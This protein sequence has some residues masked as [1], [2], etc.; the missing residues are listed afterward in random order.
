MPLIERE[1]FD[2]IRSA[3]AGR[4]L[5]LSEIGNRAVDA[6]IATRFPSYAVRHDNKVVWLIHQYRQ[7]Y[8]QI[9]AAIHA[10]DAGDFDGSGHAD[11]CRSGTP[12]LRAVC[13][14]PKRCCQCTQQ[15]RT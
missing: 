9:R 2:L 11:T 8:E 5:D 12:A 6:V 3:L 4:S 13:G 7:V 1:R 15:V 14:L 10:Q